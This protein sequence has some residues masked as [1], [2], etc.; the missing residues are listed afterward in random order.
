MLKTQQYKNN[1]IEKMGQR[2]INSYLTKMYTDGK[3]EKMLHI[4][5]H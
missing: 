2:H 3:H 1:L 5:Y 4:I